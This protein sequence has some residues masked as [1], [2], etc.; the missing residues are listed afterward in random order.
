MPRQCS[1]FYFPDWV[2]RIWWMHVPYDIC[3]AIVH[4][5][6]SEASSAQL[7]EMPLNRCNG[8]V[9]IYVCI[10]S[11]VPTFDVLTYDSEQWTP[12]NGTSIQHI[13]VFMKCFSIRN[14]AEWI[15]VESDTETKEKEKEERAFRKVQRSIE[16]RQMHSTNEMR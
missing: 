13:H 12:K 15:S 8:I 9:H 6:N 5:V 16:N 10:C 3:E 7:I 1:P 11:F 14:T 4:M 2:F